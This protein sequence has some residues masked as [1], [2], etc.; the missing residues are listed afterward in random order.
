MLKDN[1]ASTF[2]IQDQ[3]KQETTMKQVESRALTLKM[4][5]IRSFEMLDDSHWTT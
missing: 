4:E 3:A 5:A 1:N 2:W